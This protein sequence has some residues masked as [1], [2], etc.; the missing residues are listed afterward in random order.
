M[1][2][3][4]LRVITDSVM[5][6]YLTLLIKG[7]KT[8]YDCCRWCKSSPMFKPAVVGLNAGSLQTRDNQQQFSSFNLLYDVISLCHEWISVYSG[9]I[10]KW[11]L[12]CC[13][14]PHKFCCSVVLIKCHHKPACIHLS[15]CY[16]F[17]VCSEHWQKHH[18]IIEFIQDKTT[19]LLCC[20][21]FPDSVNCFILKCRFS[22]HLAQFIPGCWLDFPPA[23]NH[24]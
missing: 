4:H 17:G 15:L 19:T 23:F 20:I 6:L 10:M 2:F 13:I 16:W 8:F 12:N 14:H 18:R 11:L 9:S 1:P 24:N 21:F 7:R 5:Q 3:R 22:S